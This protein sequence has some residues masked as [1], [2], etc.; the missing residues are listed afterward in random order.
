MKE[1]KKRRLYSVFQGGYESIMMLQDTNVLSIEL[2]G[3]KYVYC[4]KTKKNVAIHEVE[5]QCRMNAKG[6]DLASEYWTLG[7]ICHY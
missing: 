1:F 2:T 5:W 7:R 3:I 6:I 4:T